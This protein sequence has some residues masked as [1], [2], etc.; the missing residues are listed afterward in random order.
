MREPDPQPEL[1]LPVSEAGAVVEAALVPVWVPFCEWSGQVPAPVVAESPLVVPAA[2]A[3]PVSARGDPTVQMSWSGVDLEKMT[4][5]GV[6]VDFYKLRISVTQDCPYLLS[7]PLVV[8]CH[9]WMKI[10]DAMVGYLQISSSP[11]MYIPL[12]RD[13]LSSATESVYVRVF[14]LMPP[15]HWHSSQCR[16]TA[17]GPVEIEV[18]LSP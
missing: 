7:L 6:D 8:L 1:P 11:V 18:Q 4:D 13:A 16:G 3:H 10:P 5:D 15:S 2:P 12:V 9:S 14:K 17:R